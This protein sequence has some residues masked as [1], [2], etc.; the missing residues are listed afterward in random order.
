MENHPRRVRDPSPGNDPFL[1][2]DIILGHSMIPF[3]ANSIIAHKVRHCKRVNT[4]KINR[5]SGLRIPS[6]VLG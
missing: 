4:V 5:G 2:N 1:L 3:P 6:S